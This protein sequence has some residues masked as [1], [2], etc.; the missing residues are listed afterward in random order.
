MTAQARG[1]GAGRTALFAVIGPAVEH[2]LSS[3]SVALKTLVG[4]QMANLS[5]AIRAGN[6]TKTQSLLHGI[7]TTLARAGFKAG[8]VAG[9]RLSVAPLVPV[10]VSTS[11]QPQTEP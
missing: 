7:R 9:E 11:P 5:E 4:R 6:A 3:G 1:G 10:Q 8:Q 2:M